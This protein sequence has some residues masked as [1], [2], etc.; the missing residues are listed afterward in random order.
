M[1][2]KKPPPTHSR[3]LST[4]LIPKKRSLLPPTS[5]T[6]LSGTHHQHVKRILN[7]S[8]VAAS[9]RT[10][11]AHR[12]YTSSHEDREQEALEEEQDPKPPRIEVSFSAIPQPFLDLPLWESILRTRWAKAA[13]QSRSTDEGRGGEAGEEG[14]EEDT[15]E[16][17]ATGPETGEERRRR[18]ERE[19]EY[20]S[21]AI[22]GRS[23]LR[24]RGRRRG[25]GGGDGGVYWGGRR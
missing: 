2:S 1:S 23:S 24:G 11:G 8:A 3:P 21:M 7:P 18:R 15:S 13:T 10:K 4:L 16:S 25:R 19:V 22:R 6:R 12:D 20:G 14:E 9:I 5:T 17:G